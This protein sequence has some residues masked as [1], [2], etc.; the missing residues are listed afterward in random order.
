MCQLKIRSALWTKRGWHWAFPGQKSM[1]MFEFSFQKTDKRRR[2]L[3]VFDNKIILVFP[4]LRTVLKHYKSGSNENVNCR[5]EFRL[6][7]LPRFS[8]CFHTL[9][10]DRHARLVR[11]LYAP[12]VLRLRKRFILVGCR[13]FLHTKLSF[14]TALRLYNDG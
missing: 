10:L 2:S 8:N 3:P 13:L 7:P 6:P 12:N 9:F 4:T 14:E 1:D 11:V 5:Q